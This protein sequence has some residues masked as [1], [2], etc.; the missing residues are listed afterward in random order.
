LCQFI[1]SRALRAR[2][3]VWAPIRLGTGMGRL[4]SLCY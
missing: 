3:S 1:I 4:R 2:Y